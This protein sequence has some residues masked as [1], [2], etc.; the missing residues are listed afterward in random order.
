MLLSPSLE[1][2]FPGTKKVNGESRAGVT[3]SFVPRWGCSCRVCSVPL[4]APSASEA[5]FPPLLL[6]VQNTKAAAALSTSNF[7]YF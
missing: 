3:L 6:Q 1:F 7:P 2:G 4:T 5:Q